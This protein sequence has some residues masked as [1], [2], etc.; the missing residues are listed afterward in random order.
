MQNRLSKNFRRSEF[1]CRCGCGFDTIDA[2]TLEILEAVREHFGP[3]VVTSGARCPAH[4][5]AIG[6]AKKSQHLLG[7][8]ADIQV[9]DVDPDLVHD[10][11]A[12]RY[13][14]ASLGRYKTFT[15]VDTRTNG[16]A[17]WEG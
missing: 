4:N 6:G 17:R 14:W 3:V 15:H 11:I 7:R 1:K 5:A 2:Q 16:P 13:S 12:E 10:W 9:K 8:A